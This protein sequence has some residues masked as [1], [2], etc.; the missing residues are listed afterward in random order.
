MRRPG[1]DVRVLPVGAAR[2]RQAVGSA[3]VSPV[4][5][6]ESALADQARHRCRDDEGRPRAA[7]RTSGPGAGALMMGHSAGAQGRSPRPAGPSRDIAG[8][9]ASGSNT[10][11]G[12]SRAAPPPALLAASS[13]SPTS[14]CSSRP[15][16]DSSHSP[17]S[18]GP[19]RA[20]V[21]RGRHGGPS[22]RPKR[23]VARVRPEMARTSYARH[24]RRRT[25]SGDAMAVVWAKAVSTYL[26]PFCVSSGGAGRQPKVRAAPPPDDDD[27]TTGDGVD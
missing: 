3:H 23:P 10:A 6:G 1:A 8:R 20:L 12:P 13:G 27:D 4:D 15:P 19:S 26:V 14:R 5:D 24:V 16:A 7:N 11:G 22:T 17:L 18:L 25:C 21:T 9:R 2:R